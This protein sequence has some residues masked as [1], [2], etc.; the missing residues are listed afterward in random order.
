MALRSFI[1]E[2]SCNTAAAPLRHLL[3]TTHYSPGYQNQDYL[4]PVLV[5][6]NTRSILQGNNHSF[7]SIC[8]GPLQ[9]PH[10]VNSQF[11]NAPLYARKNTPEPR[12]RQM[13]RNDR[14]GARTQPTPAI[15]RVPHV[16]PPLTARLNHAS[17]LSP[18]I[19]LV[20]LTADLP[21]SL[22]KTTSVKSLHLCG[23]GGSSTYLD[24]DPFARARRNVAR[25]YYLGASSSKGA[26]AR[27]RFSAAVAWW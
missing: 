8:G 20:L 5:H 25:C 26:S 6:Q 4:N 19:A 10:C 24:L 16:H 1:R 23:V 22:R 2:T 7:P 11:S 17:L 13:R 9:R 15:P 27:S 3:S 12:R 18:S 21:G 14:H